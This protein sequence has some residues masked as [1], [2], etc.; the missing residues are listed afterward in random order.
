MVLLGTSPR[1]LGL[2]E[3]PWGFHVVLMGGNGLEGGG[4]TRADFSGTI[5]GTRG[6]FKWGL[7]PK[8]G[9]GPEP[10]WGPVPAHTSCAL[11]PAPA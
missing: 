2:A 11:G 7:S 8:E 4:G 10:A 1:P 3:M 5:P 6:G 9:G